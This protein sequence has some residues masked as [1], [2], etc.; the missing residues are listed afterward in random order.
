MSWGGSAGC[1]LRGEN[2]ER[3]QNE[4]HGNN[5]QTKW[6]AGKCTQGGKFS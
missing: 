5:D 1:K 4:I 6:A 3:L 2:L